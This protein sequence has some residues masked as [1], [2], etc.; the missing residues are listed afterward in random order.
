[1]IE[2]YKTDKIADDLEDEKKIGAAEE[3]AMAKM[4]KRTASYTKEQ[5]ERNRNHQQIPP[6]QIPQQRTPQQMTM[7]QQVLPQQV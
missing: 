4:K 2:E 7:L 5:P 6:Q 3:R 1:M